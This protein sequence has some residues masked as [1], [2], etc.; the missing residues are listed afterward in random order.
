TRAASVQRFVASRERWSYQGHNG[1]TYYT[2]SATIRTTITDRHMLIRIPAFI[3][4]SQ[5]HARTALT[6]LPPATEPVDTYFLGSRRQWETMT[7]KILKDRAG[8]YLSIERGGFSIGT[9]GVYYDLGPRDS[10]TIAAHEGW[11]QYAHSVMIGRLP[12]WLDE[13]IACYLEGFRWDEIQPDTPR[14]LPW[15]NLERY[16]Q[17]RK[18]HASGSLMSL[19]TLV[20]NRPQDLMT[21][22]KGGG[23]VLTYYAQHWALVHFFREYQG[24]RYSS[25]LAR[26]IQLALGGKLLDNLSE[27]DAR[28]LRVRRSGAGVLSII[29]PGVPLRELDAQYQQFIEDI[30]RPGGR[31]AALSGKSPV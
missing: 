1:W 22:D 6:I 7:K 26:T 3:E 9:T 30:V 24:G 4:L 13:G 12:V 15:A 10:F 8:V 31:N 19:H 16:D 28:S 20:S 14:F 11:H 18:A 29:A 5:I 17:L 21:T 23:R 2:P 25:G 27:T